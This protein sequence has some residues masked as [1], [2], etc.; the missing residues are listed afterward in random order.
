MLLQVANAAPSSAHWKRAPGSELKLKDG[1]EL[2]LGS[3]GC[4]VIETS[5]HVVS[6]DQVK[7][8]TG[9]VLPAASVARTLNVCEPSVS[10]PA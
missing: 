1:L 3:D 2:L 10:G 4:A 9:P 6:T 7:L 8:V 5:G